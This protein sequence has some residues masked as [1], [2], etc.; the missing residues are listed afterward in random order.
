MSEGIGSGATGGGLLPGLIAA[1]RQMAPAPDDA[2]RVDQIRQ[3]EE[4]K[5]VAA[6]VQARVTAAFV[7]SQRKA[8]RAAGV[9]PEQA[10]RGIA[11]Q[12]G[13]AK[14]TS[15]FQARRYVGGA[16]ILTAEL[17]HTFARL[18]TGETT[19]W[20][21]MIVARE[22]GWLSREDR[23]VVDRELAP[24]LEALGDRKTENEAKAIAY[25]LDPHGYVD[26]L[27][28]AASERRV[29]LRPAPDLVGVPPP[30]KA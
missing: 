29:T 2:V 6:A 24:R 16:N 4:L 10:E 13:L 22:T 19:E 30:V 12:V 26:R 9:K 18:Q 11:H 23:T 7:A 25:R 5:S 17:P 3:L 15:P 8:N 21:A 14:R 20:R 28:K 27:G 1:L